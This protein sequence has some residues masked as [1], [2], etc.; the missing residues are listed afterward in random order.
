MLLL[1][2]VGQLE[3]HH[4]EHL[5]TEPIQLDLKEI[6]HKSQFAFLS[7]FACFS[8]DT[9]KNLTPSSFCDKQNSSKRWFKCS[10]RM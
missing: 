6:H 9:I 3:K 7:D 2:L 1:L 8:M 4:C 10:R 5:K